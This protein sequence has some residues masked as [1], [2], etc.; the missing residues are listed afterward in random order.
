MRA[1]QADGSVAVAVLKIVLSGLAA[2]FVALLGPSFVGALMALKD[3]NQQRA[4]GLAVVAGGL[5]ASVFSP[6]FWILAV[7]FFALFFAASRFN[8]K[9]L[10]VI[11]FWTP[12]V[13]I[14][15]LGVWLFSLFVFAWLH[16][17]KG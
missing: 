12:T 7:S 9:G 17:R 8:T 3:I 5:S 16:S 4:T 6:L 1:L 11:L 10:R 14:S 2:I 15:T 13:L